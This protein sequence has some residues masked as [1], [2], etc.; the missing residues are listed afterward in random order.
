MFL[1]NNKIKIF[2]LIIFT[3]KLTIYANTIIGLDQKAYTSYIES[4]SNSF[5]FKETSGHYYAK[6]PKGYY[7]LSALVFKVFNRINYGI[8]S[9]RI[10]S[11]VLGIISMFYIFKSIDLLTNKKN[12]R[13]IAYMLA[14]FHPTLATNMAK[15][16]P[17]VL[18][19]FSSVI[20]IYF[21]IK[22]F[23]YKS[24]N[25][26]NNLI[27]GIFLGIGL[28][29]KQQF[30]GFIPFIIVYFLIRARINK[31]IYKEFNNLIFILFIALLIS[32]WSFIINYYN[33][34][35]L[36]YGRGVN[37]ENIP[38]ISLNSSI[39]FIEFLYTDFFIMK[40][41]IVHHFGNF[42][43]QQ[44]YIN[45]IFYFTFSII[46]IISFIIFL[47]H[48][49]TQKINSKKYL[50]FLLISLILIN[51]LGIMYA[52]YVYKYSSDGIRL[53]RSGLFNHLIIIEVIIISIGL[54]NLTQKKNLDWINSVVSF[55]FAAFLIITDLIIMIYYN[56]PVY[57]LG[58]F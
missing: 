27:L 35:N 4:L 15:I 45:K 6:D 28:L 13:F 12:T 55:I 18:L 31:L 44:I 51:F 42:G 14:V 11:V 2:L 16:S 26:K 24:L 49:L 5:S 52:D 25:I 36:Q 17:D 53:V 39:K 23:D 57:A 46:Y 19:I 47:L 1:S 41:N 54:T 20:I 58:V 9:L 40:N 56:L 29:S 3:I 32:S 8:E 10:L 22:Y 50:Y 37:S 43:I 34:G 33:Y 21:L 7:L 38:K 30:I 48:V